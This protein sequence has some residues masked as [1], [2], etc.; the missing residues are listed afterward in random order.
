MLRTVLFIVTLAALVGCTKSEPPAPAPPERR[1]EPAAAAAPAADSRPVIVAFGDSLSEGFG[2]PVGQSFPD[3]LQREIDRAGLGYRVVNMGVSGDTTTGGLGRVESV[4]AAKPDVVLLELGG[5]D[6][7][8]GV[9]V[10]STR[11]NLDRIIDQLKDAN[12]RVVLVG[13]S[14][15]PNYGAGYVRAFEAMYKELAAQHKTAFVPFLF[16]DLVKQ[17]AAR[18]N[19]MQPDGI[20]PTAEGNQIIASTVFRYLAPVLRRG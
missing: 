2:A 9:P 4:I 15:P 7:L 10:A 19:L 5:N 1:P 11:A 13:M 6:G 16:E 20:H 17:Y 3:F 14:L 18:P 12:I 8:R